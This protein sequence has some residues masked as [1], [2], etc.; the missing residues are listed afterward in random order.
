MTDPAVHICHDLTHRSGGATIIPR[1]HHHDTHGERVGHAR[2]GSCIFC[3]RYDLY[4]EP[5]EPTPIR[6]DGTQMRAGD[7]VGEPGGF[8]FTFS[9]E[10]LP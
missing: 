4:G 8:T 1:L 10:E 9:F 7:E 3:D 2:F 6:A 5:T